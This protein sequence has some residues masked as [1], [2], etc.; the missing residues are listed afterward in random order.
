[1]H[2]SLNGVDGEPAS[3][4]HIKRSDAFPPKPFIK[5]D[6]ILRLPFPPLNG[7]FPEF[8]GRT[9]DGTISLTN[10]RVLIHNKATLHNIPLGNIDYIDARDIFYLNVFCKD[11][12]VVRCG[13]PTNDK[14]LSMFKRLQ[15]KLEPAAKNEDVFAFCF[16]TY[17]IDH[18]SSSADGCCQLCPTGRDKDG[19]NFTKEMERLGFDTI[20]A[21]SITE[22]NNNYSLCS[23]YPTEHIIPKGVQDDCLKNVA[24]F[25]ALKRFPSVTWRNVRNGAVLVRSGQPEMGIFG[26]RNTDDE[27]LLN[28]I[29]LACSRNPGNRNRARRSP[30]KE[31][32]S[33][34]EI[35]S[36][37]SSSIESSISGDVPPK[38]MMIIDCRSYSVAIANR[39]KGGGV[40]CQ[41]YYENCEIQFMNLPNI[42]TVRNSFISL[43]VLCS[44]TRDPSSWL[45]G[46]ESTRWLHHIA[47]LMKAAALVVN[48]N[49]KE[50]RSVLVHC[51]D[52]WDRTPQVISLA[53]IMLDPYYRTIE[54]FQVLVEREWLQYGHKFADRCGNGVHSDDVNER[55]PVFLQWLECVYQ[56]LNQ[57]PC[58][59]EFTEGYLLKLVQHTYSCLFGTFLCNTQKER[60]S[61]SLHRHTASVWR[62]LEDKKFVNRL[63]APTA[64]HEVLYPA[65]NIQSL[66]LWASVYL[67]NSSSFA[68]T[69]DVANQTVLVADGNQEPSPGL[70]KTRSCDNLLLATDMNTSLSRRKS[71]PNIAM[72]HCDQILLKD[73]INGDT[74]SFSESVKSSDNDR[75][76]S[77]NG[78][79]TLNGG[80][81]EHNSDVL[82]NGNENSALTIQS[83]F[84][85]DNSDNK[86]ENEHV[87]S[88]GENGEEERSNEDAVVNGVEKSVGVNCKIEGQ[89]GA[90]NSSHPNNHVETLTFNGNM[91][92]GHCSNG[93]PVTNGFHEMNVH[94]GF[95]SSSSSENVKNG[96]DGSES[97][98]SIET[99]SDCEDNSITMSNGAYTHANGV[100]GIN[101]KHFS[102]NSTS[103]R[104]YS[105]GDVLDLDSKISLLKL[106]ERRKNSALLSPSL[107]SST[108]TVTEDVHNGD[109]SH[110]LTPSNSCHGNRVASLQSLCDEATR[111]NLENFASISTSTSDLSDSRVH[112]K[113][114]ENGLALLNKEDTY[115]SSLKLPCILSQTALKKSPSGLYSKQSESSL[116]STV[117]HS[118]GSESKNSSCP[119]TPAT[120]DTKSIDVRVSKSGLSRHLDID[121]LTKFSDPVQ[122]QISQII[123]SYEQ[124]ML[125][126]QEEITGLQRML[127]Q[128]ASACNG[129]VC[130]LQFHELPGSCDLASIQSNYSNAASDASWDQMDDPEVN[131]VRWVP[132]HTVTHCA[133]CDQ[134]F[135]YLNRKHHCRNCGRIFCHNCSSEKAPVPQQM[136]NVD[137]RV[138]KA[139]FRDIS[140]NLSKSII[141]VDE[142]SS[143]GAAASN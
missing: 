99:I 10:Y 8:I 14:C 72:D 5:E 55:C 137:Q 136:T 57:F 79:L 82:M 2:D 44:G 28:A 58:Q 50:G 15:G 122:K 112:A 84:V 81:D 56:L 102:H 62:L 75:S 97:E 130:N 3:M 104:S 139:C 6:E 118:C 42:H 107:E 18:E 36:D 92:N 29:P 105:N 95:T 7:E 108:D 89:I 101:G 93:V 21:W 1:M 127:A 129:D 70:Q 64:E 86:L 120:S 9:A 73:A 51:S 83:D 54:G 65:T 13:F 31:D 59:F 37:E 52:G 48:Y 134:Q 39:A 76:V 35:S 96:W 119:P 69:E 138:C 87:C 88:V 109:S 128:H 33:G 22:I 46:L 80:R 4:E 91:P 30:S 115:H 110:T 106:Q 135:T 47:G 53:E 100:N 17:C 131:I 125:Q 43:R 90:E 45:S 38:K 24:G 27:N 25:R 12:T 78:D 111:K 16:Y 141:E 26:W 61:E 11:A 40:E 117:F 98:N 103:T 34:S 140:S 77:E 20:N 63:Y 60:V 67:S 126:M 116:S 113:L 32:G 143:L 132:D 68:S 121:G 71:D 49:E 114:L 23:S 85:C 142:L 133:S 66:K 41:E 123:D 19:Y 124:R 74:C 94:N